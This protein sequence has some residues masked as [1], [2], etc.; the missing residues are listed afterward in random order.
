LENELYFNWIDDEELKTQ[1]TNKVRNS[2]LKRKETQVE[3]EK[4]LGVNQTKI[5]QIEKGTCVDFNAINNY[6][7]YFG[8]GFIN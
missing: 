4:W 6:I 7:N 1:L 5:K 2:K 3:V 8:E